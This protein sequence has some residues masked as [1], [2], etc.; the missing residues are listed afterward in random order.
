MNNTKHLNDIEFDAGAV[1]VILVFVLVISFLACMLLYL[2]KW[3]YVIN[4]LNDMK[5]KLINLTT[6]RSFTHLNNVYYTS[7]NIVGLNTD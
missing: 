4:F 6:R 3:S 1:T 7:D 2:I 5:I